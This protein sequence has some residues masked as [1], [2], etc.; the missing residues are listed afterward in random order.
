MKT[1]IISLFILISP[2]SIS[3]VNELWGSNALDGPLGGGLIYKLD[4]AGNNFQPVFQFDDDQAAMHPMGNMVEAPNGRFYGTTNFGGISNN[5]CIFEYYPSTG[6]LIKLIQFPDNDFG[7]NPKSD[8]IIAD[9]GRLYGTTSAGGVGNKGVV[10]EYDITTKIYTKLVDFDGAAKGSYPIGKLCQAS[11]GF[12]YGLTPTGGLNDHGVIYKIDP[13]NG[14]YTKLYDLNG[15]LTGRDPRGGF[16]EASNGN[17]F[18]T[19]RYGGSL[20]NGTILELNLSTGLLTK[21]FDFTGGTSTGYRPEGGLTEADNGLL[22]GLNTGVGAI[23]WVYSYNFADSTYTKIVQLTETSHGYNPYGAFL[24]HSNGLL[25]AT[26]SDG[27]IN[28]TGTIIRFNTLT[29]TLTKLHDFILSGDIAP[30]PNLFM[31]S[32][33]KIYGTTREYPTSQGVMF[34]FNVLTSTY[35]VIYGFGQLPNAK[36]PCGKFILHTDNFIYGVCSGG[37][38]NDMGAIFR[39]LPE[40]DLYEELHYFSGAD[41]STPLRGMVDGGNGKFYGTTNEGGAFDFGVLFEFDPNTANYTK[42]FDFNSVDGNSPQ[43]ELLLADNGLLYGTAPFGGVSNNGTL[44]QFDVGSNAFT[45][46]HDFTSSTTGAGPKGKLLQASNG[47]LYGITAGG[48]F[49]SDGTLFEYDILTNIFT[50]KIN[51]L[52]SVQGSSPESPLV[53]ASDGKIYGTTHFGGG[54]NGT[55][56][57]YDY[58]TNSIEVKATFDAATDGQGTEISLTQSS[59]GKLYGQTNNYGTNAAGTIYE[60]DLLTENLTTKLILDDGITGRVSR[61]A[62]SE[63]YFCFP[64]Y[65]LNEYL[66]I[67]PGT[68]FTALMELCIQMSLQT[69]LTLHFSKLLKVATVQ[70]QV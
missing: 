13:S 18:T 32:D 48:G 61:S 8:L 17:L 2:F 62:L 21:E 59:N 53:E 14:Q 19:T 38:V 29:N 15:P 20:D 46:L 64:Q 39:Y 28:G 37:G 12:L 67:C 57:Q 42:L 65:N 7:Q 69:F 22:Y 47:K 27:G 11:D 23:S 50:T 30:T 54:A 55:L 40:T 49:Y 31:G 43:C 45:K 26:C 24:K 4:T 52:S 66:V 1:I 36:S 51:F 35:S 16:F 34:E 9:N 25:Y 58:T 33:G 41:G 5:G 6:M 44:F 68:D 3:Q 10:F 70:L 56:F 63:F 60:Y